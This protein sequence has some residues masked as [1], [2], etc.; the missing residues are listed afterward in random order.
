LDEIAGSPAPRG[1]G[2]DRRSRPNPERPDLG[3]NCRTNNDDDADATSIDDDDD[4]TKP[5][6]QC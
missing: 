2:P 6:R 3:A 4:D 5:W 1:G